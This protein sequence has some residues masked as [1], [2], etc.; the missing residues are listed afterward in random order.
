M[1]TQSPKGTSGSA[2]VTAVAARAVM[3]IVFIGSGLSLVLALI[4]SPYA[5]QLCLGSGLLAAVALMIGAYFVA[6]AKA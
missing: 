1:S 4:G 2:A 6:K 5:G 3:F